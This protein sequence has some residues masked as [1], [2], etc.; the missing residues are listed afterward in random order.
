MSDRKIQ[1]D[2]GWVEDSTPVRRL[3]EK[4]YYVGGYIDKGQPKYSLYR[5]NDDK[6]RFEHVHEFDS[7]EEL[8]NMVKLLLED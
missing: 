2:G 5:K 3:R 6:V 4:G 7:A 1:L 8:N